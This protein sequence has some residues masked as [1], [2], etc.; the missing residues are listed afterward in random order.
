MIIILLDFFVTAG[1]NLHKQH[2]N[3]GKLIVVI[4]YQN[5]KGCTF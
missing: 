4:M 3:R 2:Y 1:I 5:M